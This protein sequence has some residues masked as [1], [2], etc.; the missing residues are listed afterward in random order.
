MNIFAVAINT[1]REALRN[2]VFYIILIFAIVMIFFSLFLASISLGEQDRI[3]KHIGLSIMEIFGLLIAMFVGVS[4]VNDEL[5]RKTIYTIIANGVRRS[6]FIL[7]KFFGLLL[8][9]IVTFLLMG[10]ILFLVLAIVPGASISWTL[11]PAIFYSL[12]SMMIIIAVA[13][14]FSSFST[15][16]LSAVL[17]FFVFIIGNLSSDLLEFAKQL[18]KEGN[19]LLPKMLK[20]IYYI[21]PHLDDLNL[22]NQVLNYKEV[23][24]S[25]PSVLVALLYSAILLLIASFI[26]SR[27]DFK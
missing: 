24:I 7:G 11:I 27:K 18:A 4:L 25:F 10:S 14:L 21:I 9:I 15:P 16:I 1:Y 12:L 13:V 19:A 2:K 20:C 26:F 22:K 17:T 5:E 6:E 23:A 3:L 8:V